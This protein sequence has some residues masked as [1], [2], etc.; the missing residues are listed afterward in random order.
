M[1][2]HMSSPLWNPTVSNC[3][4]KKKIVKPQYMTVIFKDIFKSFL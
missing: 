2:G 4:F 3:G 1:Y